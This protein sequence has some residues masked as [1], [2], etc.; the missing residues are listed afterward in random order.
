MSE[1][2]S[3]NTNFNEFLFSVLSCIATVVFNVRLL[4]AFAFSKKLPWLTQAQRNYF[5]NAAACSKRT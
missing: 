2:R 1:R 3:V 5:E 4:H